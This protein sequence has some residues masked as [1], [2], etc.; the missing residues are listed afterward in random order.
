MNNPLFTDEEIEKEQRIFLRGMEKDDPSDNVGDCIM[1]EAN[2]RHSKIIKEMKK[3]K[4]IELAD[5]QFLGYRL[6][7][8]GASLR[9]LCSSMGLTK[10]EYITLLEHYGL[11]ATLDSNDI[12]E[13]EDYFNEEERRRK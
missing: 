12:E 3:G 7:K 13:I 8:W 9:E 10:E 1:I 6:G 4:M 11:D 5:A 2:E